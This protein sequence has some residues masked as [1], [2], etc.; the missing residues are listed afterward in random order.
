MRFRVV[1]AVLHRDRQTLNRSVVV[2]LL[3]LDPADLV[4]GRCVI[5]LRAYALLKRSEGVVVA[6]ELLVGVAEFEMR[7]RVVGDE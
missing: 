6:F 1:R 5:G 3:V 2:F 7:C 4:M